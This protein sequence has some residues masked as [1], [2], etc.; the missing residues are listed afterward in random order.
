MMGHIA[1]SPVAE[2]VLR[3]AL[4]CV[5]F[6]LPLRAAAQ[7]GGSPPDIPPG[8]RVRVFFV[9]RDLGAEGTVAVQNADSLY[10]STSCDA[11]RARAIAWTDI[12]AI[13][14]SHGMK[15][16]FS[17]AK[18]GALIGGGI[19]G[20]IGAAII[21]SSG[22]DHTG[23]GAE[24]VIGGGVALGALIGGGIGLARRTEEW[25]RLWPNRPD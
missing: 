2:R 1:R 21:G 3:V 25:M 7:Q 24:V 22:T 9:S 14:E 16:D 11:C 15:G 4:L 13:D 20:L 12:A 19:G 6:G 10:L 23:G 17:A 8:T 5:A 18:A